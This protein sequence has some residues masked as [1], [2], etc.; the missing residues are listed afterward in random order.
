[1]LIRKHRASAQKTAYIQHSYDF[2]YKYTPTRSHPHP[3]RILFALT[4]IHP[5][6]VVTGRVRLIMQTLSSTAAR[7]PHVVVARLH[8]LEHR[9]QPR[10]HLA[11]RWP[12]G[13]VGVP[14][15]VQKGAQRLGPA[16][17]QR[18]AEAALATTMSS[19]TRQCGRSRRGR[20]SPW[21]RPLCG[22]P[23]RGPQ[24]ASRAPPSATPRRRGWRRVC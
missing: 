12:L 10:Q 21:R 19:E 24:R 2:T 22:R 20:S 4:P 14:A 3:S 15:L 1:M 5:L 9:S 13:G 23:G 17:V 16:L 11:E 18:G 7:A 6:G 8:R